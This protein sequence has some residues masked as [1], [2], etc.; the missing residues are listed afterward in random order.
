[1]GFQHLGTRRRMASLRCGGTENPDA[2]WTCAKLPGAPRGAWGQGS[3]HH[4]AWRVDDEAHQDEVRASHRSAGGAHPT[5]V[6]DRFWFKSVYFKEPGGVL[7][8][9]ATDGPG[10]AVDEDV[11][12]LGE[13][14]V[15]PPW[16]EP[17]RKAIEA[18]LPK[19]DHAGASTECRA[20]RSPSLRYRPKMRICF[21][22]IILS[23][24][25][26]VRRAN[27]RPEVIAFAESANRRPRPYV[28]SGLGIIVRTTENVTTAVGY[29][30]SINAMSAALSRIDLLV[31]Q[32]EDNFKSPRTGQTL[33]SGELL[34]PLPNEKTAAGWENADWLKEMLA[35][36]KEMNIKIFAWWPCF[37]DAQMAAMF[38]DAAYPGP[39]GEKFVDAGDPR[40]QTRQEELLAKLL[41]TY[42]V[43]RRLVRLGPLRRRGGTRAISPAEWRFERLMNFKWG[44][45]TLENDYYKAR[46]YEFRATHDCRLDRESCRHF[47]RATADRAFRRL[48][49]RAGIHR[50][51]PELSDARRGPVWNFSSRWVT[52][53][54]GKS[55]RNGSAKILS[56]PM[57]VT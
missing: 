20:A 42:A 35:R 53:R 38:P 6:I 48:S 39:R 14:L 30:F 3:I 46:W 32:D 2:T 34:V 36:A 45:L 26:L 18:T 1:M 15:L 11:A 52:G 50:A 57:R 47:A 13:T 12:H 33:Q 23:L 10:F 28:V 22:R 5:P 40:V 31:K 7:F 4:I 8:E 37:H 19:L 55:R 16:L 9:L 51:K 24:A 41:D 49:A 25:H 54:I 56:A 27:L 29:G 21:V 44:R 17:R 43:R